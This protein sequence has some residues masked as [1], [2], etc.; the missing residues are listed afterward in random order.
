MQLIAEKTVNSAPVLL[1]D[2]CAHGKTAHRPN[3]W[4]EAIRIVY[5]LLQ[6]LQDGDGFGSLQMACRLI[7]VDP[8][9]A[10]E[11]YPVDFPAGIDGSP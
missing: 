3:D 6:P 7:A 5:D 2:I 9:I 8:A 11:L 10:A 1:L 4:K